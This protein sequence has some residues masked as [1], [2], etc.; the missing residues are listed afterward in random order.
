MYED[1]PWFIY[2]TTLRKYENNTSP[3]WCDYAEIHNTWK[4]LDIPLNYVS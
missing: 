4:N 2:A 3:W 1:F